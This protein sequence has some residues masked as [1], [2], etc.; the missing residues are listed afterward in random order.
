[1]NIFGNE[2]ETV[3]FA[4][5]KFYNLNQICQALDMEPSAVVA[6]MQQHKGY[7]LVQTKNAAW[8]D[9]PTLLRWMLVPEL[10]KVLSPKAMDYAGELFD[11]LTYKLSL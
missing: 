9:Y 10:Q 5:S 4:E 2:I 3:D 1:M 6:F 8:I 11:S 7:T